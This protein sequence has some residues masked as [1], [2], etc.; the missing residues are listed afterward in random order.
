MFVSKLLS[1]ALL[2]FN[3]HSHI[4]TVQENVDHRRR[5]SML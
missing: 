2:E 5:T 1:A 3:A 4:K